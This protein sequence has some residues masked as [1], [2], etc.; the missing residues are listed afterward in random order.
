MPRTAFDPAK[1]GFHF[2]NGFVNN[3]ADLGPL[4]KIT[5]RGRCGGMAYAALDASVEFVL[6]AGPET[7]AAHGR[8]LT[9]LL[10]Q[11]L[12]RDR[13]VPTSP[14]DPDRLRQAPRCTATSSTAAVR[15]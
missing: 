14:L 15:S 8:N 7:V 10:Y 5:T 3:V 1:H 11:R 4:G 2:A 9:E 12:P 6:Q 13:C